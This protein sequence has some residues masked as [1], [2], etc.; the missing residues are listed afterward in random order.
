MVAAR[1]LV[2][3]AVAV[4][5]QGAEP[6]A[7][8]LLAWLGDNA[9]AVLD[10]GDI[11]PGEIRTLVVVDTRDLDRLGPFAD[12]A[13][14]PGV[15][16]RVYDHHGPGETALPDGAEVVAEEAG[17]N[18]AAMVA[19]LMAAGMTPTPAEATV[20]AAGVYEDTGLF[21][22]AGVT[23]TDFEAARWL[24]ACGADLALVGRLLRQD[25]TPAQVHLL[26]RLLG[27]AE[28]VS[29]LRHAVLLA[30]VDDPGEVQ[31][32]ANVVQRV[33]D[34]LEAAAFYALIQQG[35]RVFVIARARPDGPDVGA[36]ARE[37]GGGGHPH[38]ASVSLPRT[39][40]AEVRERVVEI[41]HRQDG[42]RQTV[43]E[44]AVRH[45]QHLPADLTLAEAAER[46]RRF[47]LSRLPVVAADGTPRGWVD[48]GLVGRAVAHGL[49]DQPLVEY[50]APLP[51][52]AP[53]DP[54]PEAEAWIL[55]RDYPLVGMVEAGRLT[56]LLTRS[57]LIRNW[58]EESPGL[59][60]PFQ[61]R[62]EE[63][64]RRD[65]TNRLRESLPRGT[66]RALEAL[67][68]LA[69]EE[70]LGA[71]LVGGLVR[72]LILRRPNDDVD[73]VVEGDAVAL[74]RAY[75]DRYGWHVHSHSRFGTAVL[76]GP[77]RER[78]DL[79]SARIEHYPYPAALPEVEAGSVK[80]DLFRRD[81]TCNALAIELDG[82]RFGHLL[83]LYGGLQDLRN[84]VIRVLHSLSFVED[85]T[86]ILRAVRFE[87]ELG[88]TIDGQS[89]RLIRNAVE[90][91]LPARLSGHRLFRELRYLLQMASAPVGVAR[92]HELGMLPFVHDRLAG[93]GGD[94][95]VTRVEAGEEVLT[96]YRLLYRDEPPVRW[97]VFLLLLLWACT[98]EELGR[99]LADFELR[100][101]DGHHLVT[102]RRRG[103]EVARAVNRGEGPAHDDVA[104]FEALER[105][106][107]EGGLALM[108]AHPE[109]RVRER[110]SHYLQHLRGVQPALSGE[111]IMA[112]GVPQGPAVGEWLREL[113][114]ARIRGQVASAEEERA[115]VR[116]GE[117]SA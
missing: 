85:P 103:E 87:S 7:S 10:S 18:T 36:V 45:V 88:F 16:L 5:S 89:Q 97:K 108:A 90:L 83:D 42:Q 80:A 13:R 79:A 43:G 99:A 41:L 51:T 53:D 84:R 101:R 115:W 22:F 47:P 38:A 19:E 31:D 55:D 56:G 78:I 37:L 25:L 65:L 48:Q 116:A 14:K 30:A 2:P 82:P 20:M 11:A 57:D 4:L 73:V 54:L 100:S 59:P 8:R 117:R 77:D 52:L 15:R 17:S 70:G 27:H 68:R 98:P 28:P 112:L 95:A 66:E 92:L 105:L 71:F 21:T 106:S 34:S 114:H 23:A 102:D 62:E 86:R 93:K 3:G 63:G 9:P 6:A 107:L 1:Y 12:V 49:G 24:Q 61:A 94:A 75:A 35:D 104:L 69:A 40:L 110:V 76:I 46:M 50:T 44:L 33:M 96:W 81:F 111:E 64:S 67:G 74:A 29:G 109:D 91:E 72:D 32:A 58:R 26:D 39:P 60:E 113:T